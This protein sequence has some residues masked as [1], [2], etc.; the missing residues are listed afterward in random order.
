VK[1]RVFL[2]SGR[3]VAGDDKNVCLGMLEQF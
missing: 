1:E 2:K 3:H